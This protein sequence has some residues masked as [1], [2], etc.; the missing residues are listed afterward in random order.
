MSEGMRVCVCVCECVRSK[1]RTSEQLWAEFVFDIFLDFNFTHFQQKFKI[2]HIYFPL[3][4]KFVNI[5][6]LS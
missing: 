2:H 5:H 4:A 3:C 6:F 1:I